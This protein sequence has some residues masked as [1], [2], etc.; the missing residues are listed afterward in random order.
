MRKA[1]VEKR[2][3]I[4]ARAGRCGS[5][6]TIPLAALNQDAY[7]SKTSLLIRFSRKSSTVAHSQ[8]KLACL[9]LS[10]SILGCE[11]SPVMEQTT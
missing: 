4:G 6:P 1:A 2:Q 9:W 8:M 11:P 10:S 7:A 3:P 5:F